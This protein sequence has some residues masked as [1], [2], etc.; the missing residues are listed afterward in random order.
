MAGAAPI[1]GACD[2]TMTPE[3]DEDAAGPADDE[4]YTEPKGKPAAS[5]RRSV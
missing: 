5:A 3:V 1:R 4:D 2:E